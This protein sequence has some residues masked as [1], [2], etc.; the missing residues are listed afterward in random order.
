MGYNAYT[1]TARSDG[2]YCISSG[3]GYQP[4][5]IAR[6]LVPGA[7]APVKWVEA[8]VGPYY[9]GFTRVWR[10]VPPTSD[11]VALGVVSMTRS[12]LSQIPAQPPA[13]LG[14]Q[15]RAVHKRALTGAALGPTWNYK[16]S[17]TRVV[18]A[19]DNRYWYADLEIPAKGD[20]FALDPKMTIKDWSG[21]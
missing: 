7:L 13:S 15:F 20:C 6:E 5:T 10:A 8:F 11:Y 2:F 3:L 21:W 12:S 17:G 16:S 18:Y 9:K 14:D 1:T 19:V 4:S